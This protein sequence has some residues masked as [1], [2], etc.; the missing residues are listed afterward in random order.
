MSAGEVDGPVWLTERLSLRRPSPD[1]IDDVLRLLQDPLT[2]LYNP[3][4]AL[5]DRDQAAALVERW[6]HHWDDHGIGYCIVSWR[7]G[8][9]VLGVCGVK[10]MTLHGRQ[11][12][13]L[14]Y[15]LSPRIWGR[16]VAT[17]AATE[18]VLKATAHELRLPVVARVRPQNRA[19]AAVALGAGL[20]R[21]APWDYLGED[22]PDKVYLVKPQ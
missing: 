5:T 16:G 14:L 17:E 19:S 15:R 8:T 18:L 11:V 1:D 4:D 9:A 7:D 6:R 12:F 13:N 21:A 2:T 22:G 3:S 20:Q 10:V